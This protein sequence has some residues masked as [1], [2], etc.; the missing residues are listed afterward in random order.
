[1]L[2]YLKANR[3]NFED[4]ELKV[5][6]WTCT[7][8]VDDHVNTQVLGPAGTEHQEFETVPDALHYL[9]HLAAVLA[10][11]GRE[12]AWEFAHYLTTWVSVMVD[13]KPQPPRKL[14]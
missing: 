11:N 8:C 3:I 12:H 13:G 14:H 6:A 9:L 1:M 4:G 7:D 10:S 5:E 2:D